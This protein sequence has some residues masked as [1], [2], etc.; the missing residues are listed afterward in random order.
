MAMKKAKQH[1][2]PASQKEDAVIY[3]VMIALA[4]VCLCVMALIRVSRLAID[5]DTMVQTY[6]AAIPVAIGSGVLTLLALAGLLFLKN[7]SAK[8]LC[9]VATLFFG[10][11][12]GSATLLHLY[13]TAV[14]PLLYFVCIAAGVLYILYEIYQRE[15][16][17]LS[18]L[19]AGAGF[20]FYI[21]ARISASALEAYAAAV[22]FLLCSVLVVWLAHAASRN[23]GV[24]RVGKRDVQLFSGNFSPVSLY[25]TSALWALCLAATVFLGGGFAYYC[26]Y[27]AIAYELIAA[28]Y[29]TIR[30]S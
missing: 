14:L 13:W 8:L 28:C 1:K 29:Y 11:A 30:L 7:K 12:A 2:Q 20:C 3:N 23:H 24:I 4:L 22:A 10:F 27:A 15:F 25:L 26:L 19:T 16:F 21:F 6:D 18:C 17:L 5:I 9:L